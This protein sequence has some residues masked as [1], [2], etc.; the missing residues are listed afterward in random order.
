[1]RSKRIAIVA[2]GIVVLL[3]VAALAAVALIDVN[4]YRGQVA[5]Q[6]AN[7]LN[8]EITLGRLSLSLLPLGLRVQNV[9]IGEA[10]A[11]QTGRPFARV[12]ELYVSPSLMPLLR[13]SF[14]LRAVELRQ[15][16]IELVR[17]AA[18]QWNFATLG[19]N[20]KTS[21][22]SAL[23]LNRLVVTGG[24]VAVTNLQ[25]TVGAGA[26]SGASGSDGRAVYRNIDVQLDDFAP[27]RAFGITLGA[28]L[29]GSGAQR[30]SVRGKAGPI[31][32]DDVAMTPF[33]GTAQFDEVSIAGAQRFLELEALEGTDAVLSGS[34]TVRNQEGLVSSNGSLRLDNTRVRG[35]DIGYPIAADFDLTH[36][37]PDQYA[38]HQDRQASPRQDAAV[39]D[40]HHQPAAGDTH[41][42]RA[43]DCI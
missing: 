37:L 26:S 5:S 35:V 39:A 22:E 17:G 10:R 16:E 11:F 38:H 25:K 24:Q 4:R 20:E 27:K 32:R 42:G 41:T 19:S 6:L 8:R 40:G 33:E 2:G 31:A 36:A 13:G 18:G 14:E 30:L 28:T 12:R 21:D 15:P 34:A 9:V 7:S 43:R 29:P 23:V 3:I 1:M